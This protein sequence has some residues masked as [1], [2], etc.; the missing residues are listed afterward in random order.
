MTRYPNVTVKLIL[1]CNDKIF[2]LRHLANGAYDFPGGRME[3][4]ESPEETLRREL[5]E[6]LNYILPSQPQFFG[7]WNYVAADKSRHSLQLQY[8]L[9]VPTR[10]KFE[11][12]E[13]AEPV[14]LDKQDLAEL[15]SDKT[16]AERL[17]AASARG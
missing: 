12:L 14:W 5:Q 9:A 10:P 13:D 1:R 16:K 17:F 7:I 4:G 3:W 2:M 6:E 11:M 15:F 8:L